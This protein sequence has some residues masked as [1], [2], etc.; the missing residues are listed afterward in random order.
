MF[1]DIF[2]ADYDKFV[3]WEGRLAAELPFINKTLTERGS[4]IIL[5]SACGTGMHAIGLAK[6]GYKTHGCDFSQ[7]MVEVA[8]SN[9]TN[10]GVGVEF[11]RAGFGELKLLSPEPMFDAILCLGNSLPHVLDKTHLAKTLTDYYEMLPAG[12]FLLIQNRNF[13]AVLTEKNRWMEPQAA[14]DDTGDIL[15][16]RFY[17]FLENGYI[18]FNVMITKRENDANWLQQVITTRLLPIT[19]TE[20]T[21]SL[22][23]AG[24]KAIQQF[25]DLTGNSYHT[26]TSPNIVAIAVK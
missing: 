1:Y 4:K 15:F 16:Q 17:D 10:T 3:N 18:D 21:S 20:L 5:D 13:D 19:S 12:G 7:K 11:F 23:R 25:G 24:F 14:T 8:T 22:T 26:Q 2:S 9:A 6:Y